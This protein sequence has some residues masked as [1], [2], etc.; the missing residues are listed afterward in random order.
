MSEKFWAEFWQ[1]VLSANPETKNLRAGQ[2]AA[3]VAAFCLCVALVMFLD[4]DEET[5]LC[6]MGAA[7]FGVPSLLL[8]AGYGCQR[9]IRRKK[10]A[11]R[12]RRN[13]D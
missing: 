13:D 11:F 4:G 10:A 9:L 8:F 6:L 7:L 1:D 12:G 2:I 3:A 5:F